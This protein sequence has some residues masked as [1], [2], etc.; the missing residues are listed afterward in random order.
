MK[1]LIHTGKLK[2]IISILAKVASSVT[3]SGVL[4]NTLQVFT[5]SKGLSF[6]MNQ[7]DFSVLYNVSLKDVE[8]KQDG[9]AVLPIKIFDGVVSSLFENETLLNLRNKTFEV[10]TKTNSSEINVLDGDDFFDTLQTP[11][12]ER[13]AVIDVSVLATGIKN[14]LHSTSKNIIKPELASIY[15]YTQNNSIYFVS[16][17]SFRLSEMRFNY[18]SKNKGDIN[19]LIPATT[20]TKLLRVLESSLDKDVDIFVEDYVYF[21]TN[22]MVIKTSLVNG[23]FPDYKEIMLENPDVKISFLKSDILNFIKQARFFSDNLNKTSINIMEDGKSVEFS[24]SN[25]A[26]GSTK[27]MI[28]ASIDGQPCKIE[29]YNHKYLQEAISVIPDSK[30]NFYFANNPSKPMMVVGAD[31]PELREIISPLVS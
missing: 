24:F 18:D 27:T 20:A 17:D 19:A 29:S 10:K 21:K 31:S 30:V 14:V 15:I 23:N 1:L 13:D 11:D 26:T 12:R 28:P 9:F 3:S 7:L 4:K 8:I 5:D 2:N 6:Q 25:S 16:T 22:S